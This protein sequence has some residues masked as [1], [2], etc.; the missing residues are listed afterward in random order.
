M[1]NATQS[2]TATCASPAESVE[3]EDLFDWLAPGCAV[4]VVPHVWSHHGPPALDDRIVGLA[5]EFRRIVALQIR[6][7]RQ[8]TAEDAVVVYPKAVQ[9]LD[10]LRPDLVV[11]LAIDLFVAGYQL[12]DERHSVAP[13]VLVRHSSAWMVH[14]SAV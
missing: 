13:S 12:H 7:Q 2:L 1:R 10:H 9:R 11:L 14:R 5:G 8:S 4:G 3:V 6:E